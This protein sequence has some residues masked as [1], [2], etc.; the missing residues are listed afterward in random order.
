MKIVKLALDPI[1]ITAMLVQQER[2]RI[3]QVFS[4]I[5]SNVLMYA[6]PILIKIKRIFA[7]LAIKI[8]SHAQAQ[9]IMIALLAKLGQRK[10]IQGKLISLKIA[11]INAPLV[12][13]KTKIVF[14]YH[15]TK[16]A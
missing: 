3:V 14:A 8:V 10:I 16:T 4:I 13:I 5:Q 9:I 6:L 2:R 1:F 15:A 12:F 7:Y 11:L